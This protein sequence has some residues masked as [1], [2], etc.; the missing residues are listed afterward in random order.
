MDIPEKY[1][2][3]WIYWDVHALILLSVSIQIILIFLGYLRKSF[4]LR[5]MRMIL[6][7]NYLIADLLANFVLAQLCNA[8]DDSSSNAVIAFW[9][10]FLILHLSGPDTITAYSMED[11][12][13]WARHLLGLGYGLIIAF[14]VLF[15]SL[16]NICLLPPTLLIFLVAIIKY[17]ERSYSLYKSS[18]HGFRNSISSSYIKL[19]LEDLNPS[20]QAFYLY[21]ACRPFFINLIPHLE[22]YT[23]IRNLTKDMT[24]KEVWRAMSMVLGYVYDELYTKAVIN[25]S[26]VGYGLRVLCSICIFLAFWLFLIVPKDD[27]AK[28]DVTITYILLV[29]SMCLDVTATIMLMFS[30]WMVFSLLSVKKFRNWS[31]FL[32]NCIVRIKNVRDKRSYWSIKM[33]QLSLLNNC[34]NIFAQN[35]ALHKRMMNW[36]VAKLRF[37]QE[38]KLYPGWRTIINESYTLQTLQLAHANEEIMK[39][40][41]SDIKKCL[42]VVRYDWVVPG[43][44]QILKFNKLAGLFAIWQ[45]IDWAIPIFVKLLDGMSLDQQVFI[46]HITTE[47]C[48]HW[49]PKSLHPLCPHQ[50]DMEEEESLSRVT[51]CLEMKTCKY[52]SN[53]MMYMV[54]MRPE[55][56]STMVSSSSVSFYHAFDDMV[57][58]IHNYTMQNAKVEEVCRKIMITPIVWTDN[59][60]SL[61]V[62]ARAL[63][64][65]MLK[66]KEDER[67]QVLTMTWAELIIQVAKNSRA[68]MHMK[69]LNSGDELLTFV[70]LL[71]KLMETDDMKLTYDSQR[72]FIKDKTSAIA[73]V[74]SSFSNAIV[75]FWA[76]FL[77]LHLGGSDTIIVYSIKDNGLWAHHL[78]VLGFG[79]I[80]AFYVIFRFLPNTC[81]VVPTLLIFLVAI[82]KNLECSYSLYKASVNGFRNSISSSYRKLSLEDL[83]PSN[84]AFYLYSACRP[85]FINLIPPL[86]LYTKTRNLINDMTTEEVWRAMSM[87]LGYVYDELY[88]KAIINHSLVGYGRR[89]LCSICIFLTFWLWLKVPKDDFGKFNVTI[90]YILLVNSMCHDVMAAIMLVFSN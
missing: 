7:G 18:V 66:V 31:V 65:L 87:V 43:Y 50:R 32:A 39:I 47:L 17:L 62:I 3:L 89:V 79:L 1:K 37:A 68:N 54:L 29:T 61:F 85:F 14:Y 41:A 53:Y 24:T 5:W 58:F 55:M 82:I 71:N 80:I 38:T 9:A 67:W 51:K 33:P 72:A 22:L 76:P 45:A 21:S 11:N 25:H 16:P 42:T 84:Q 59:N 6:W 56:M 83:N 64:D 26:I 77:I 69:H 73:M 78:L 90:T 57:K 15:R 88:T 40:I 36:I 4:A 81:L 28:F 49:N 48:F 19:S 75:A 46:W 70:W 20:N 8:M 86:E 34:L 74:D 10:P 44:A 30:D 23:K 13:L 2:Q 63:T 52:L 12:E 60:K 27:F 35:G